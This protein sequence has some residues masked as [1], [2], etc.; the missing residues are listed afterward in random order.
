[1]Q[2]NTLKYFRTISFF[3]YFPRP[4]LGIYASPERL[5]ALSSGSL[6]AASRTR[7][8]SAPRLHPEGR[9]SQGHRSQSLRKLTPCPGD[10]FKVFRICFQYE[11]W[12]SWFFQ[13]P[14][15]SATLLSLLVSELLIWLLSPLV[16]REMGVLGGGVE[17]QKQKQ[18]RKG[19]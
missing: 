15:S 8:P 11:G 10:Q 14:L 17:R 5:S 13:D 4:E 3:T 1:M 19:F 2:I 12:K 18:K 9:F 7:P 6:Q 16:S